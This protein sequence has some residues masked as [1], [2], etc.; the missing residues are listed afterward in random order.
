MDEG[1]RKAERKGPPKTKWRQG[2]QARV[3]SENETTGDLDQIARTM[4]T[5]YE[6]DRMRGNDLDNGHNICVLS[7]CD[8][9]EDQEDQEES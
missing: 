3:I 2:G 1:D 5:Q 9:V 8:F 7:E 4:R 6:G